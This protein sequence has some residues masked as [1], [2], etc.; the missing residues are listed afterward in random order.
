VADPPR[1]IRQFVVGT[2]GKNHVGVVTVRPNSEVRNDTTFGVLELTLRPDGYDW[3]FVPDASG[4]FTDS[5][6]GPCHAATPG[7]RFYAIAPCRL[8][9]TRGPA[10]PSGGPAL[11]AG[12]DRAFPLAGRCGIP[13]D[14]TALALNVTVVNPGGSGDLRLFPA[15]T[16]APL[17]SAVSFTA[18]R[19][20]A[21]NALA[22][23][24]ATG[25]VV[26]RCDMA[27]ASS[28]A[29]LVLDVSGYFR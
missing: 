8:V 2:G 6:S 22:A 24:S 29:H 1:G 3:Q 18:G 13:A 20:R 16:V 15:G 25:Q 7:R 10:G 26:V 14:A 21:G 19:T 9:D 23:L 12:A 4:T 27:P 17:A 28:T 5:G 11:M